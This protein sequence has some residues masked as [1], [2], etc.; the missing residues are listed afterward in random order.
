MK[1]H[2]L[3][4]IL[5]A[6]ALTIGEPVLGNIINRHSGKDIDWKVSFSQTPDAG[7]AIAKQYH[8]SQIAH[9]GPFVFPAG[10]GPTDD[11]GNIPV[12]L[13]AQI[14]QAFTNVDN[15]LRFAGISWEDVYF[16]KTYSKGNMTEVLDEVSDHLQARSKKSFART[17]IGVAELTGGPD[18]MVEVE[19]QAFKI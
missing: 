3:A 13:S 18:M 8:Y 9:V 4:Y 16:V 7:G 11:S 19:V 12:G 1:F 14:K 5:L 6:P 17:M 15:V 10:Q 2:A